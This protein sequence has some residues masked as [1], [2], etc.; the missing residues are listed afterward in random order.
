MH[1]PTGRSVL[2]VA[3][4]PSGLG[5]KPTA[6]KLGDICQRFPDMIT[7]VGQYIGDPAYR[8]TGNV[9]S[10]SDKGKGPAVD[11]I[12]AEGRESLTQR[13]IKQI[14]RVKTREKARDEL[15]TIPDLDSDGVSLEEVIS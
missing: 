6:R 1:E 4:P 3:F 9:S 15:I 7:E 13:L 10:A 14:Q 2:T 11:V 12:L 5:N 8:R